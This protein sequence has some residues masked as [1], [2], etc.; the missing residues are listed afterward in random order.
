[1]GAFLEE[2]EDSAVPSEVRRGVTLRTEKRRHCRTDIGE[3]SDATGGRY[4]QRVA[5]TYAKASRR[6]EGSRR[7]TTS[8]QDDSALLLL[9][10]LLSQ[11]LLLLL[12][13]SQLQLLLLLPQPLLL[14][15]LSGK[16]TDAAAGGQKMSRAELTFKLHL[17]MGECSP[18]ASR[19]SPVS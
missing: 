1:M 11:P 10:L 2:R 4:S 7:E 5:A 8:S 3:E 19:G 18:L 17:L 6:A 9:L 12:L 13:L 15:P 16:A 14:L